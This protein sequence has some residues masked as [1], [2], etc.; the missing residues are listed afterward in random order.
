MKGQAIKQESLIHPHIPTHTH[1]RTSCSIYKR[2]QICVLENGSSRVKNIDILIN[3][4]VTANLWV[5]RVL[6]F[7]CFCVVANVMITC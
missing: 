3:A 4:H 1:L 5:Q 6:L 2:T 7:V